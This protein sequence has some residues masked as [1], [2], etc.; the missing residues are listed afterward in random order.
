[1]TPDKTAKFHKTEIKWYPSWRIV[2]NRYPPINFFEKIAPPE[3]WDALM[4]IESLTDDQVRLLKEKIHNIKVE[5]R[6]SGPGASRIMASFVYLYG[7][8][9]FS[10]TEFGAYYA[11]KELTT[12]IAETIYHREEF[13][14]ATNE[15][16]QDLENVVITA[17]VRGE[18]HDLRGL[19]S[20]HPYLYDPNDYSR[21]QIIARNLRDAGSIG[22]IYDSVRCAGGECIA[23]FRPRVISNWRDAKILVYHWNGKKIEGYYEKKGFI[24]VALLK[25]TTKKR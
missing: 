11:A 10:S 6:L 21:S 3:D 24:P 23:V 19:A 15:K 4:E 20:S 5:D 1:M 18:F 14:R 2:P 12:A 7:G 22:V 25:P 9:R 17:N 8:G 13:L 16:S